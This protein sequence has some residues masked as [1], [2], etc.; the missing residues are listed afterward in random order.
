MVRRTFASASF[1]PK[2][3]VVFNIGGSGKG[4]RLIVNMRYPK[5][6]Y[7]RWVLTH[8]EYERRSRAGTL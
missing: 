7:V 1:L 4:Y 3:V 8:D 2:N 6:V 5:R